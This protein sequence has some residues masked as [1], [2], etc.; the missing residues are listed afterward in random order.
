[1]AFLLAALRPEGPYPVLSLHGPAGTAKSTLTEVIRRVIDHGKPAL[2]SLPREKEDFFIAAKNNHV[3]AFENISRIPP[4]IADLM[5]QVSTGGGYSRRELYTAMDETVFDAQRPQVL[6]GIEDFVVRGDLA[7]RA[8]PLLLEAIPEKNRR[9]EREFWG[10][11]EVVAPRILGALLDAVA[12]GLRQLPE[13]KLPAL[14]R[15]A[16]FALWATACET[17]APWAEGLTFMTAYGGNRAEATRVVLEDDTVAQALRKVMAGC[18]EFEGTAT[19]LL[20]RLTESAACGRED[21]G[22]G[23]LPQPPKQRPRVAA[24]GMRAALA[25]GSAEAATAARARAAVK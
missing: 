14:P 17:G 24:R 21:E 2:R 18:N 7:D 13:T 9:H 6:N 5:C 4:W 3:L 11:F 12:N 16:D 25:A 19:Q 20:D 22:M 23:H 8:L 10:S 1:V 15:M